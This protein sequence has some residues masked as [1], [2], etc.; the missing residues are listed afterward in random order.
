MSFVWYLIGKK[1]HHSHRT[2]SEY[3]KDWWRPAIL[4][5]AKGN[6]LWKSHGCYDFWVLP[7][8][9]QWTSWWVWCGGEPTDEPQAW[10]IS[11]LGY[12]WSFE[13][14]LCWWTLLFL[15]VGGN[16]RLKR[17]AYL[18]C[19]MCLN[20]WLVYKMIIME[21][22]YIISGFSSYLLYNFYGKMCNFIYC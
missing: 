17:L 15:F 13:W 16:E 8:C 14:C 3:L 10:G 12:E 22:M 2:R 6:R 19:V 21:S 7:W 11:G 4:L 9:I 18:S 20:S 5:S 1:S